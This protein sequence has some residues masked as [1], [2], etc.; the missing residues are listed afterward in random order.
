MMNIVHKKNVIHYIC[1][2]PHAYTKACERPLPFYLD[3]CA[4]GRYPYCERRRG[5]A[6]T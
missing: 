2:I 5:E 4:R 1:D 6:F 3:A